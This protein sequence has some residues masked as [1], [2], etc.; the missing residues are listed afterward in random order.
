VLAS[1][2]GDWA[3]RVAEGADVAW[4]RPRNYQAFAILTM[5]RDLY[6]LEHGK[7]V[8]KPPALAWRADKRPDDQ[9]LPETLRLVAA[10]VELAR[11][12]G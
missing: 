6:V 8:P 9:H 2:R 12:T 10:A 11:P 1:L 4:L 3:G 5:C 7:V